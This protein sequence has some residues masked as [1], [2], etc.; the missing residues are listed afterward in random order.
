MKPL[1]L[2][3]KACLVRVVVNHMVGKRKPFIAVGL[4]CKYALKGFVGHGR[5]LQHPGPLSGLV[6]VHHHNLPDPVGPRLITPCFSP[7]GHHI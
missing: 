3:K 7:K 1:H 6:D 2:R 4:R 5:S